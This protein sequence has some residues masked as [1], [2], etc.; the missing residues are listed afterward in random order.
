MLSYK[1]RAKDLEEQVIIME[2]Y[3]ELIYDLGY[4]YDGFTES[5]DL[6]GLIDELVRLA[7]LGRVCNTTEVMYTDGKGKYWNILHEEV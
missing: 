2:K 6:K 3:F 5:E 7:S 4:D 1:K